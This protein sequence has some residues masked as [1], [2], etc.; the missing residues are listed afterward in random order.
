VGSIPRLK[1]PKKGAVG[2]V[3]AAPGARAAP[4]VADAAAPPATPP[5]APEKKRAVSEVRDCRTF[6]DDD[7]SVW[8]AASE[9]RG[10]PQDDGTHKWSMRLYAAP[11]AGRGYVTLHTVALP[12]EPKKLYTF[13]TPVA[14]QVAGGHV[15]FARHQ[16]TLFGWG[17]G[18]GFRPSG[19]MRVFRGGYPTMPHLIRD[20]DAL[21]ALTSMK[22]S[23]EAYELRGTE[24]T[25]FS[26]P[27]SLDKLEIAGAEPSL[28]EPTLARAGEQRWLS[29]QAGARR[30][31]RLVIVPVDGALKP[32]GQPFN[33]TEPGVTVYESHIFGLGDGKLLA[34]YIQNA[35]PGAEL[36]SQVLS[37]SVKT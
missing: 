33:V 34:L 9:L 29:Y 11:D 25:K 14:G 30:E 4:P 12:K 6:V 16:G 31:G 22:T 35:E 1:L 27:A 18:A 7:G 8:A 23:E 19:G 3:A 26:L 32:A 10:D 17:L 15:L 20:G 37:C 28:A 24:L 13:E 2:A 5:A 36:V 21:W